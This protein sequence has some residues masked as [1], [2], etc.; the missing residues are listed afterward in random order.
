MAL[1]DTHYEKGNTSTVAGRPP[2]F[3]VPTPK[4]SSMVVPARRQYLRQWLGW[5]LMTSRMEVP[6]WAG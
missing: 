2:F 4:Q 1:R 6:K 5:L 3:K